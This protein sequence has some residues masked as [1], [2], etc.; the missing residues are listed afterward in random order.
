MT[1]LATWDIKSGA[2]G[3]AID[4]FKK[5]RG[6]SIPGVTIVKRWHKA[7]GRGGGMIFDASNVQSILNA[8]AEWSEVLDI[9]I[10]PVIT[11]L[12]LQAMVTHDS[13]PGSPK[14]KQSGIS[15]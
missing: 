10:T 9:R 15:S 13:A 4:Q 7:D 12:E 2:L 1:L 8:C 5:H 11:D 6:E 14:Q 3:P